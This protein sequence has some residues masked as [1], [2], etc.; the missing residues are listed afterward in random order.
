MFFMQSLMFS[1][2]S[3]VHCHACLLAACPVRASRLW[4]SCDSLSC[5]TMSCPSASAMAR[6]DNDN[7]FA[8][9]LAKKTAPYDHR[10][11]KKI[12]RLSQ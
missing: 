4:L 1:N 8:S 9:F 3:W 7:H 12:M 2:D 10:F 5:D 11:N 6:L